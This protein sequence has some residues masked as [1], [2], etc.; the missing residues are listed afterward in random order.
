MRHTPI[1]RQECKIEPGEI[2]RRGFNVSMKDIDDEQRT[3][4]FIISNERVDRM[5]D[6]ISLKGWRLKEFRKNPI[7]LFVHEGCQGRWH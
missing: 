2:I 4:E 1:P 6:V 5:G 3:I 7:V